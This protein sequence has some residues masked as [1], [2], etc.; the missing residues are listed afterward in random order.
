[1]EVQIFGHK[2]SANTRKALRFFA[3]RRIRTHFVDLTERDIAPGELSRF[4]Q[5]FG[6]EAVLDRDSKRFEQLGLKHSTMSEGRWMDKLLV[7]PGLLKLPLIRRLG[8][9]GGLSVGDADPDWKSWVDNAKTT[10]P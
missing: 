9:G 6:I 10:T 3:E 5:Q 2:K 7:D 1:M 4:V 8:A